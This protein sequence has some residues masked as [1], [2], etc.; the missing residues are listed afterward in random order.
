MKKKKKAWQIFENNFKHHNSEVNTIILWIVW[1]MIFSACRTDRSTTLIWSVS[2]CAIEKGV[3]ITF[4]CSWKC[5]LFI[6]FLKWCIDML[7][8]LRA[9]LCH[10]HCK[11]QNERQDFSIKP[12][13][14]VEKLALTLSCCTESPSVPT[15]LSAR[16][17]NNRICKI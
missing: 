9:F 14:T 11:G 3:F 16:L 6:T 12:G 5:T 7:I 8:F 15:N 4:K 2:F 1:V 17:W 10:H 13:T